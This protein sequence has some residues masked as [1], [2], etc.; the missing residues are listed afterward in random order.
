[1]VELQALFPFVLL[2]AV[3]SARMFCA[4]GSM[5][6]TCV[7]P[8]GRLGQSTKEPFKS[9]QTSEKF[10][11]RSAFDGTGRLNVFGTISRR[12]S[13]DQKKNVLLLSVL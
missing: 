13:C 10:P 7:P 5:L 9:G 12:H 8:P 6:L 4:F 3:I 11:A 2:G 1:M